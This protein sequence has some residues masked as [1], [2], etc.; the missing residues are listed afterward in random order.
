MLYAILLKY[1]ALKIKERI[2]A[3]KA[4]IVLYFLQL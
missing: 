3:A 4:F 1:F 2:G